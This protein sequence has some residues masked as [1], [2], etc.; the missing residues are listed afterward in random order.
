MSEKRLERR[1]AAILA[2]DVVGYSRLMRADEAGT[3]AQL[4]TLRRELLDPKVEEHGG[5]T[6]KT[7][8]DGTLVEFASA[9]DAVRHAVEVQREMARRNATVPEDRRMD[10][11]IGIN[12]GDVIVEGDDIYGDGVNIAARLEGLAEPGGIRISDSAHE[13]VRHKLDFAF[14]D[15]GEQSVKNIDEPVRVWRV[16]I[17]GPDTV[18]SPDED[19]DLPDKPSIAVLPFDN[20]SGDPDQTYF[21]DGIT[22]DIITE[23]SRFGSLF[24]IAR[25]SSFAFRGENVDVTEVGRKLGVQNVVEGSVR[26]A[27]NRIRVT[28]QLIDAATGRHVWA[29]RYDRD[30]DDIF[31]VQDE[32]TQAIVAILP[33]R[34]DE[35]ARGRAERKPT[36][37]MTAYDYHLLGTQRLWRWGLDDIRE[38]GL[39]ARKAVDLDPHFARAHALLACTHLWVVPLESG[40]KGALEEALK[41]AETAVSLDEDDSWPRAILGLTHYELGQDDEAESQCRRAVTL[42]PNDADANAILGVLMVYFGNVEEGRE[43]I[44]KAFRLNPYPHPWYHWYRGLVAYASCEYDEAARSINRCRPLDRWHRAFLA[45]CYAQMGRPEEAHTEITAFVEARR[46]ELEERGEPMPADTIE[47]ASFRANRY[48]RQADRDHFLEGL[49]L[50]GLTG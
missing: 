1:L 39:L 10:L 26:K 2:A 38:A 13:Q 16:G 19:L 49:R 27:G 43:W 40:K 28:V 35:A 8:G 48:R 41:Y 33:G 17:A 29:E 21:S 12:V 4:K 46:R 14:E 23:L 25:N 45:A 32:I 3:L 9:V 34:L 47:L 11:R 42:N 30:L 5:R 22:E 36:S 50:A 15:M 37:S 44:T 18:A 24:V 7:T 6:V 20:M 31:A